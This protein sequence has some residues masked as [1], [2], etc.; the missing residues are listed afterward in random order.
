M[1]GGGGPRPI[2]GLAIPRH[3]FDHANALSF[4][5]MDGHYTPHLFRTGGATEAKHFGFDDG[6]IMKW[7]LWSLDAYLKCI[8]LNP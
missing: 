7:V 2:V 3:V 4:C 1:C 5:E 6:T 8:R